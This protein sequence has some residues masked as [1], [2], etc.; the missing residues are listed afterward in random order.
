MD[1]NNRFTEPNIGGD[2]GEGCLAGIVHFVLFVGLPLYI[3]PARGDNGWLSEWQGLALLLWI[4]NILVFG[5]RLASSKK[6]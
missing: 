2:P 5:Y 1:L 4:V 3:F 6:E